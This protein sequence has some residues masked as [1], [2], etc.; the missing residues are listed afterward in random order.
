MRDWVVRPRQQKASA[1]PSQIGNCSD[2]RCEGKHAY[3]N[4]VNGCHRNASECLRKRHFAQPNFQ[5]DPLI[6]FD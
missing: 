2:S 5:K 3:L 6:C 1:D 4:L